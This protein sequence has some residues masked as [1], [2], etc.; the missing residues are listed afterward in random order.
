MGELVET[1]SK[2]RR[3][4]CIPVLGRCVLPELI[5]PFLACTIQ[6]VVDGMFS[7]GVFAR[8]LQALQGTEIPSTSILQRG[9]RELGQRRL[10][11]KR[12]IAR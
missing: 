9:D 2:E 3:E 7:G 6:K 1:D 5:V 10:A 8:I 12:D 4:L 11:R